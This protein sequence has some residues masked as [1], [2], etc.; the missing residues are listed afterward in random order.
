[1]N[2]RGHKYKEFFAKL[3]ANSLSLLQC[4]NFC[5]LHWAEVTPKNFGWVE[6]SLNWWTEFSDV[7]VEWWTLLSFL[8]CG[9]I[10]KMH[11][12]H[13]SFISHSFLLNTSSE[14]FGCPCLET[15]TY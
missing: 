15:S 4:I 8:V 6:M 2:C 14:K 5:L 10:L 13:T 3:Y 11:G 1:M 9:N 12:L 7:K